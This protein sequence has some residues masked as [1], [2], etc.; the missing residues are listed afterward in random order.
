[1]AKAS[2]TREQRQALYNDRRW[3]NA[4]KQYLQDHPLCVMCK[5]QGRV[6]SATV[7]DHREPH[8]G[9]LYLFWD[10]ENWQ[11]LCKPHHDSTKQRQEH[12]G[13]EAGCTAE[14][15]PLDPSHHWAR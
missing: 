13:Q 7:V 12:R 4:R 8:E 3:R 5:Q 1:M 10:R 11:P 9:D 6:V 2:Y 14:G 15:V